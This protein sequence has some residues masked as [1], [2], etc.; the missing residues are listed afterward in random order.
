VE[1]RCIKDSVED[2]EDVVDASMVELVVD[3]SDDLEICSGVY[4]EPELLSQ[5]LCLVSNLE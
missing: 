1:Q 5:G 2:L 3:D 4:F